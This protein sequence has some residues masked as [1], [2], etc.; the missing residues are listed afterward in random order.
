MTL[1]STK[2]RVCRLEPVSRFPSLGV[3]VFIVVSDFE[4]RGGYVDID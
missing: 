2:E 3:V 1:I 4:L